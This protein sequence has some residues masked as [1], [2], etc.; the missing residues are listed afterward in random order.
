MVSAGNIQVEYRHFKAPE[1]APLIFEAHIGMGTA[2][3]DRHLQEFAENVMPMVKKS[4]QHPAADGYS[5]HPF[6]GSFG[7]HVSSFFAASSRFGTPGILSLLSTMLIRWYQGNNDLVHSHSVKNIN[8][9]LGVFDGSPGQY[10]H[11]NE[12]RNHIAW[13]RCALT[14]E[15]TMS[16]IF[17]S[18]TAGTGWKS[19]GSTA[20]GLM[21]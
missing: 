10:F 3:K 16:F 12:R 13:D 21:V 7:Y 8:E 18:L 2:G 14:T 15:R 4:V 1:T 17:S 5:E 19:T 6:Y 11:T 20:T 9:G